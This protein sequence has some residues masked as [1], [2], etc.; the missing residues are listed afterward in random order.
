MDGADRGRCVGGTYFYSLV[1]FL[2]TPSSL[3]VSDYLWP[4]KLFSLV[5]D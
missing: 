3:A 2:L 5:F 1:S 4:L